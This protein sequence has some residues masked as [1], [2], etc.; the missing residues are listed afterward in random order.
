MTTNSV[1]YGN[2]KHIWQE[3]LK[4]SI[5]LCSKKIPSPYML[6]QNDHYREVSKTYVLKRHLTYRFFKQRNSI[7]IAGLIS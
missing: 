4:F 2:K 5:N 1:I 3:K 6:C 7:I